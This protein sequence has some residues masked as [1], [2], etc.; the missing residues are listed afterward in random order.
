MSD[1]ETRAFS[2]QCDR[3]AAARHA[4]KVFRPLRSACMCELRLFGVKRRAA[5]L[6][7]ASS[8]PL[9]ALTVS[10]DDNKR[11]KADAQASMAREFSRVSARA[12]ETRF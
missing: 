12:A 8:S 10:G 4:H 1:V 5:R 2:A 9:C 3:R 11:S 7:A 6:G